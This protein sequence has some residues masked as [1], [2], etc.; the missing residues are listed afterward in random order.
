M[1]TLKE[2]LSSVADWF[3]HRIINPF[4]AAFIFAWLTINWRLVLAILSDEK[5]R[6]KIRWIDQTLYPRPWEASWY[7]LF[8]PL[9]IAAFYIFAGPYIFR[10]IISYYRQQQNATKKRL[11]EV[12][13]L[14]VVSVEE[15]TR[16]RRERF[17]A[18][19][20]LKQVRETASQR[21][22]DSLQEIEDLRRQLSVS[23]VTTPLPTA[24]DALKANFKAPVG[25]PFKINDVSLKDIELR[26]LSDK[27]LF[28]L[29]SRG[30]STME[31]SVVRLLG[32]STDGLS[33]G[34]IS[35]KLPTIAVIVLKEI[36]A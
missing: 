15:A 6:E 21:E 13:S 8:Q 17:N 11:M 10:Y 7:C 22:A 27:E 4:F 12:D 26:G 33:L 25:D 29:K 30:L 18:Q 9:A 28:T 32:D 31:M 24:F 14:A 2:I 19:I 1:E 35:R 23:S 3:K 5:Y 20:E 36:L 16:L 34:T